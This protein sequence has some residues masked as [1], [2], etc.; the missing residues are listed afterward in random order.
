[1]NPPKWKTMMKKYGLVFFGTF[2]LA[3]FLLISFD[4]RF[5]FPGMFGDIRIGRS[6][7]LPFGSATATAAFVTIMLEGYKLFKHS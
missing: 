2:I 6:F 7:Y 1:M 3:F 5:S 4:S